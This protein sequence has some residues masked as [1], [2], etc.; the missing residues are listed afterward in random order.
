M[1]SN[2]EIIYPK[3][4]FYFISTLKTE[5]NKINPNIKSLLFEVL[6]FYS[7]NEIKSMFENIFELKLVWCLSFSNIKKNNIIINSNVD[8]FVLILN[9]LKN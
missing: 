6:I 3:C 7:I 5:I 4:A 2:N 1:Q 9:D 8:E